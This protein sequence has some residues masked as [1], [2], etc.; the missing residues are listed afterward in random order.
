M[1]T[2]TNQ[3]YAR[4]YKI[5]CSEIKCWFQDW[6]VELS[7]LIGRVLDWESKGC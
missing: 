5:F 2:V 6:N 4:C 7:G 3:G 1:R